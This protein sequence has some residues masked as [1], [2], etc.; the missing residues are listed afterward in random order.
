MEELWPQAIQT[1]GVVLVAYLQLRAERQR[2][3]QDTADEKDKKDR[4]EQRQDDLSLQM[5]TGSL[6]CASGDL[7]L[8]TSKAVAGEKTNGDVTKAQADYLSALSNY[9]T[10]EALM[11]QKYLKKLSEQ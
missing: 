9:H 10:K 3:K 5:A 8:T 6:I 4:E 2:K 11:A 7:A 1:A